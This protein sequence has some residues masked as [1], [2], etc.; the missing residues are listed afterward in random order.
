MSTNVV[1]KTGDGNEYKCCG[2]DTI[3]LENKVVSDEK[4]LTENEI[5]E[6]S[7]GTLSQSL[8]C[9]YT[10]LD[11]GSDIVVL[12]LAAAGTG[13]WSYYC[14]PTYPHFE[15]YDSLLELDNSYDHSDGAAENVNVKRAPF[16]FNRNKYD[17][18]GTYGD[19]GYYDESFSETTPIYYADSTTII[20]DQLACVDAE[21]IEGINQ[22]STEFPSHTAQKT[23]TDGKEYELLNVDGT[24]YGCNVENLD[25]I[26]KDWYTKNTLITAETNTGK[27]NLEGAYL[28]NYNDTNPDDAHWD[29]YAITTRDDEGNYVKDTLGYNSE[30]ANTFTWSAPT[31]VTEDQQEGAC[32]AGNRCW[33]GTGCVDEYTEHDYTDAT[34]DTTHYVC[35]NGD[36]GG[37]VE[38]KYDWYNN[39]DAAA[40]DYCVNPYSCVCSSNEDDDT[41]CAPEGDY[42]QAGCTLTAD[43]FKDDHFCEAIN[44]Q[45]TNGDGIIDDAD[46]SRW[47]SRTKFLAFQLM[48]I[49]KDK[50]T[51]YTLFCDNYT[52]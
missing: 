17:Y 10:T 45:D 2:D 7:D 18:D 30:D 37:G 5:S 27:C 41:F 26:G 11:V 24:L 36:W 42:Y 46:S 16:F 49:A 23:G 28:C 47:T 9:L 39:T 31:W 4:T 22:Q 35:N 51:D 52:D 43:F 34:G 33:D 20:A 32:C 3:W 40:I 12:P 6:I 8:Y 15:A 44:P 38:T 21:V 1:E 19:V 14:T 48:E 50:G 29:W 25:T 13:V